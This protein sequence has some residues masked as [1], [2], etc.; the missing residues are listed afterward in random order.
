MKK[1][2]NE[3]WTKVFLVPQPTFSEDVLLGSSCPALP[4]PQVAPGEEQLA[5]LEACQERGKSA[6]FFHKGGYE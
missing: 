5:F 4:K 1:K 6:I 3:L 2:K